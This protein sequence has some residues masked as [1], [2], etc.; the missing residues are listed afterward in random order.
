M[1][2]TK[3]E[4]DKIRTSFVGDYAAFQAYVDGHRAEGLHNAAHLVSAISQNDAETTRALTS[5]S[6]SLGGDM[7]N[8][9]HSPNGMF[10]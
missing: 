6:Q 1:T 7:A 4:W 3:A 10:H 2:Q 5:C 8:L 9:S